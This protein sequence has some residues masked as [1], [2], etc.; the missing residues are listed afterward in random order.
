MVFSAK[1][2]RNPNYVNT[3]QA[4]SDHIEKDDKM[5]YSKFR[6]LVQSPQK[7]IQKHTLFINESGLYSLIMRSKMKDAKKFAKW[8]T[9]EVL[10]SIRKTG[11]YVMDTKYTKK[12]EELNNELN[13]KEMRIE[14]L[15]HNQKKEKFPKENIIY[16]LRERFHDDDKHDDIYKVGRSKDMNSRKRVYDT[17]TS[18]KTRVAFYIKVKSDT[19]IENCVK[20]LLE[21]A[22]YIRN[23]EYYVVPLNII[24]EKIHA[25]IKFH[26]K[27]SYRCGKCSKSLKGGN[28]LKK[29]IKECNGINCDE[30]NS[31]KFKIKPYEKLN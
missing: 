14:T 11:K 5:M 12:L 10:P 31:W 23:K 20:S 7:Y 25:C 29:H 18:D 28:K 21:E 13:E 2:G 3:K 9:K 19:A 15:E 1:C 27:S 6:G 16:V 26:E 4:I 22:R 30:K 24:I 17:T 8:V